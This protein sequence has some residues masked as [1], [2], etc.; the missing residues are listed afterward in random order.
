MPNED[1]ISSEIFR[2]ET[3]LKAIRKNGNL[4]LE[5]QICNLLGKKY[6]V[7]GE[8]KDALKFN[9]FD[10]EICNAMEDWDGQMLALT[11][12]AHVYRR[13]FMYHDIIS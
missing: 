8:W 11:N 9:Y 3:K 2:L 6:E 13:Y 10:W 7:I 1:S 12:M 4:A 5:A